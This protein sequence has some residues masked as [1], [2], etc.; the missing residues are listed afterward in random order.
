MKWLT[1]LIALLFTL[2]LRAAPEYPDKGPDIYDPKANGMEKIALAL[3]QA[4]AEG[5]HVLLDFGANWCPWCRKLEHTFETA[6]EV[7][8]RLERNFVV[9]MIDVN[10]RHG[11][12]RNADVNEKYGN[13]IHQGLPVLVVLGADGKLL[14]TRETGALEEGDHHDP[15]KVAAF[16]D[17]WKPAPKN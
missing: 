2:P 3:K 10:M 12:K 8:E 14:I 13:P 4:Q 11:E 1:P 17:R 6:P 7:R 9:V 15:K 16:L 5:K